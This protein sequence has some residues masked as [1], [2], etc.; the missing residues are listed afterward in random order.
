MGR[1]EGG[2]GRGGRQGVRDRE[3]LHARLAPVLQDVANGQRPWKV[4]LDALSDAL[5]GA[6]VV[7]VIGDDRT[8]RGPEVETAGIDEPFRVAFIEQFALR[9]PWIDRLARGPVGAVG[10]GYET[11]PRPLLTASRFYTEWMRPQGLAVTRTIHAVVGAGPD[12]TGCVLTV[13]QRA[14]GPTLEIE[15]VA[16]IRSLMPD[17]RQSVEAHRARVSTGGSTPTT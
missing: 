6:A 4:F 17:L 7:L 13:F 2:V 15:D 1:R 5:G 9:D 8:D 16:L 11:L 10:F 12:R 3:G 14:D